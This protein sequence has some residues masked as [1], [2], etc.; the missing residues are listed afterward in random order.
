M[1][2]GWGSEECVVSAAEVVA[3]EGVRDDVVLVRTDRTGGQEFAARAG[4]NPADLPERIRWLGLGVILGDREDD[5]HAV[6]FFDG[7]QYG[8]EPINAAFRKQA[9]EVEAWF[10]KRSNAVQTAG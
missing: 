8:V 1:I 7:G 10:R 6:L 3:V 9:A 5:E 2:V 4:R